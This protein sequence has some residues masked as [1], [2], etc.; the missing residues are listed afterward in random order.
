MLQ[1]VGMQPVLKEILVRR[2]KTYT[3]DPSEQRRLV[4]RTI[5]SSC[6]DLDLLEGPSLKNALFCVMHN[7]VR[8]P[9]R[10]APED[11]GQAPSLRV[12]QRS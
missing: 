5:S 1:T 12:A 10:Q 8:A 2:A 11:R 4:E 6:D 9:I 3:P 7:H